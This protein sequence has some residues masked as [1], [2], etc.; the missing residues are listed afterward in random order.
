[1]GSW[2]W[3]FGCVV[4]QY[5]AEEKAAHLTALCLGSEEEEGAVTQHP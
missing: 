2:P 5:E 1:M 3:C 4:E